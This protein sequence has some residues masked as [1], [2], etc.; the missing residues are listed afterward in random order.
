M[1]YFIA[2]VLTCFTSFLLGEKAPDFQK[3]SAWI[4]S[5]PLHM[6]ALRGKVVLLD[7]WDYSCINCIRTLPHR[8]S[9]QQ[10]YS[11]KGFI[12]IGVHT[13]EFSFEHNLENVQKAVK[14]FGITYPVALDNDYKTWRAY[15]NKYWPTSYLIDRNGN[16]ILQH[17]GE[18]RYDELENAVRKILEMPEI[19]T[20][21]PEPRVE[22]TGEMYLGSRRAKHYTKEIELIPNAVTAYSFTKKLPLNTVGITGLWRVSPE[23]IT[24]AGSNCTL[25]VHFIGK[26][27]HAVLSGETKEPL[28]VSL[29]GNEQTKSTIFMDGDRTYNLIQLEGS[30]P[31]TIK[32]TVPA[33]VS[34]YSLTFS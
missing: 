12:V 29:D 3:I 24:S 5:E 31:H 34:I 9:L 1:R 26:I 8:V 30:K 23:S 22:R 17:I 33:G 7:F 2:L 13:P 18:G 15:H 6:E 4:N 27:V 19:E 32:V 20:K 10:K 16:I 14:R 25:E 21:T 11:D 28:T